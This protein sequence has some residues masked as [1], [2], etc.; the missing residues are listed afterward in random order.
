MLEYKTLQGD[1]N[2]V[3]QSLQSNKYK[4]IVTSPP[5][6][7][8]RTYGSDEHELGCEQTPDQFIDK[9]VSI[10]DKCKDVLTDDGSLFIVIGDT[11]RNKQKLMIP[12]HLALKLVEIGYYFQEDIIWYKK[13]AMSNSSKT[14]LTQAYEF[15]LFLTKSKN[16][17]PNMDAI[18]VKGNETINEKITR[19]IKKDDSTI[20]K[21]MQIHH[22]YIRPHQGLDGDTPAD[23]AGIHIMGD[24]KW[25][26]I[27]QNASSR[28]FPVKT[29]SR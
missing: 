25:K 5:Y 27:I 3:I 10:F 15:V 23:R 12:H 19:G 28:H 4:L 18:R 17:S 13:N 26:T 20:F 2:D 7:Q 6:Y 16:P 29:S 14:S 8:H 21:G 24:N 9:L 1:A 11:R 22:N